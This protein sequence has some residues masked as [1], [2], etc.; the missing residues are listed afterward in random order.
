MIS[1]GRPCE[2]I[3][4]VRQQVGYGLKSNRYQGLNHLYTNVYFVILDQ[5]GGRR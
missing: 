2:L 5:M 3:K 4:F 1:P